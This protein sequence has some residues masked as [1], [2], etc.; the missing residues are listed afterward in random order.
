MAKK[1]S[2]ISLILL[3]F[4]ISCVPTVAE[5]YDQLESKKTNPHVEDA[6]PETI[7]F[8]DLLDDTKNEIVVG[9]SKE[10]LMIMDHDMNTKK[11][12]NLDSNAKKII[13]D[14]ID[15]DSE[16]KANIFVLT[17]DGTIQVHNGQGKNLLSLLFQ[18]EISD[19]IVMN[20]DED[21]QN[22]IVLT[23]SSTIEAYDPSGEKIW[24]VQKD[25]MFRKLACLREFPSSGGIIAST[26]DEI[27]FFSNNGGYVFDIPIGEI[28]DFIIFKGIIY[29]L[30]GRNR[31]SKLDARNGEL[32]EIYPNDSNEFNFEYISSIH[33]AEDGIAA[34]G[35]RGKI[36]ILTIYG[37]VGWNVDLESE[38]VTFNCTNLD[39]IRGSYIPADNP[40]IRYPEYVI[41]TQSGKIFVYA[42]QGDNRPILEKREVYETNQGIRYGSVIPIAENESKKIVTIDKKGKIHSFYIYFHYCNV[43]KEYNRGV[44]KCIEGE[45]RESKRALQ[46]IVDPENQSERV[47]RNRAIL[48]YYELDQKARKY[49]EMSL[50]GLHPLFEEG[51]LQAQIGYEHFTSEPP[52]YEEA[53]EHLFLAY[54]K[55]NEADIYGNE[56]YGN[57]TLNDL[58]SDISLCILYVLERADTHYQRFEYEQALD[59]FLI[60]YPKMEKLMIYPSAYVEQQKLT[61]FVNLTGETGGYEYIGDV[62]DRIKVCIDELDK[63]SQNALEKGDLDQSERLNG[64]LVEAAQTIEID[65][66]K[67]ESRNE[68]IARLQ[69]AKSEKICV[70]TLTILFLVSLIIAYIWKKDISLIILFFS[71]FIFGIITLSNFSKLDPNDQ[72]KNLQLLSPTLIPA[73]V[74]VL[75]LVPTISFALFHF[76]APRYSSRLL[77]E[78]WKSMEMMT[79][80]SAVTVAIVFNYFILVSLPRGNFVFFLMMDLFLF[81]CVVLVL[82]TLIPLIYE[83][84]DLARILKDFEKH[85]QDQKMTHG[86]FQDFSSIIYLL[87][88]NRDLDC[89]E[90]AIHN[91]FS[92]IIDD[93]NYYRG[94]QRI[95]SDIQLKYRKRKEYYYSDE[96]ARMINSGYVRISESDN[97][98]L[99][100]ES[101]GEIVKR[102]DALRTLYKCR[103]QEEYIPAA[104]PK[105]ISKLVQEIINLDDNEIN[106]MEPS[107]IIFLEKMS[108]FVFRFWDFLSLKEN[109]QTE[110][111]EFVK[112]ISELLEVIVLR[113]SRAKI[114]KGNKDFRNF[115]KELNQ[116]QENLKKPYSDYYKFPDWLSKKYREMEEDEKEENIIALLYREL[117]E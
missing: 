107:E 5:P 35:Q 66:E 54:Q 76:F 32:E 20:A 97:V 48:E 62:E 7:A 72:L 29:V 115:K 50:E 101:L 30:S 4:L 75:A 38:I 78:I 106:E 99:I 27:Y 43:L 80:F 23:K 51:K 71:L 8:G 33:T 67:Y 22:E 96:V 108:S 68:E 95:L 113:A 11:S 87:A 83:K 40:S 52:N 46:Y 59:Y 17:E 1:N 44:W 63:M 31:I 98:P 34:V 56:I 36:Q 100:N 49:F 73:Y 42:Y 70:G 6:I 93:C 28:R 91:L 112:S 82:Y 53:I 74:T 45:Y 37:E 25:N 104:D 111:V 41:F 94:A 26:S 47:I 117:M 3:V 102:K 109:D 60:I 2:I 19:F 57:K 88:E 114:E 81:G 9:T 12:I 77:R 61:E 89:L 13:I 18:T 105:I 39:D 110:K 92:L 65:Y 103:I 90:N 16:D 14:Q 86:E 21:T 84:I 55:F 116:F 64:L 79:F 10:T 15:D 24:S 58:I 69:S 85:I